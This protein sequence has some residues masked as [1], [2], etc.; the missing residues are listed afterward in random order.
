ML[1]ARW[2]YTMHVRKLTNQDFQDF[3]NFLSRYTETSMFL[4]SNARI[5][6][7]EYCESSAY[8]AVYLA[9]IVNSRIVGILAL[10]WNGSILFQ[11]P[12]L[13]YVNPFLRFTIQS[14]SDFKLKGILGPNKQAQKIL[15][16]LS[17]P[18]KDFCFSSVESSYLLNLENLIVPNL[19]KNRIGNCR[20][21]VERDLCQLISWRIAY[22][23]ETFGLDF[24]ESSFKI[25]K[26]LRERIRDQTI[27]VLET[28]GEIVSMADYNAMLPDIY[29]IGGVWTPPH[30]RSKGYAKAVIAGALL[31]ARQKGVSK[32]TLFTKNPYAMRCYEKIGFEQIEEYHISLLREPLRLNVLEKI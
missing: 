6:G 21:A 19:L 24:E 17:L 31:A 4:R 25:E 27:F 5:S 32:A 15:K 8:T 14:Y 26:D 11:I 20:P 10:C 16:Y 23:K 3:D 9:A 2:V 22:D 1:K 7:L 29:Q 28:N 18:T 30:L 12:H 13:E